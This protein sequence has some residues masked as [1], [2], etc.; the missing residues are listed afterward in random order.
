M[1]TFR[2]LVLLCLLI[3][4]RT[5]GAQTPPNAARTMEAARTA[6]GMLLAFLREMPKG[7]DLHTHLLGAIYAESF[8]S[9]G[10]ESGA[11]IHTTTMVAGPPPCDS[12]RGTVPLS[13]ALRDQDFYDV[14]VDA[15]SMRNWDPARENGHEQ[16]FDS[17]DK[18]G[19]AGQGRRGEMLAEASQRAAA[20]RVSYLEMM[21]TPDD[22]AIALGLRTGWDP[23]FARMRDKLRAAGHAQ[24]V[25]AARLYYA[26]M[27]TKQRAHLKCGSAGAAP[28]CRV[29]IRFLYQVLRGLPPQAVY[30]QIL[31]AFE[32]ASAD[33]LVVGFNLVMP[34]DGYIAMRDF[35]LHMSV[36]DYLHGLYPNVKI[37]LHAGELAAGLV[38]PEGLRFHI[39]ESILKGHASRIGHGTAIMYEDSAFQTLELMAKRG[40][41]LESSLASAEG[42]LTV[43]GQEH[44]LKI[45]QIHNV[46]IVLATDDEG[47]S[48]SELTQEYFKAATEQGLDY[49]AL[50]KIAQNS[51]EYSFLQDAVKARLR[52]QLERDFA[53]FEAKWGPKAE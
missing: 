34:E 47:V 35:S 43:K 33:S 7:A 49:V 39:R 48:R 20:N 8:I 4:A 51:I 5:A 2:G 10:A 9:W 15:W 19:Y 21:D 3:A 36:I 13:N 50:K 37:S 18:F 38:P 11:C 30:A 17:F 44:P 14:I 53:A 6:P 27:V 29:E 40:I 31:T 46:P 52:A 24:V 22:G 41:A 28:G 42:I 12:A 16:F 26:D 32:A 1:M 25:T 45:Y 23:D